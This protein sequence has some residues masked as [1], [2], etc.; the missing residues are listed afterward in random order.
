MKKAG[1]LLLTLIG[2][3][4]L[5]TG[6]GSTPE[7]APFRQVENIDPDHWIY[8]YNTVIE[9][10]DG[11]TGK[12]FSRADSANSF[13]IGYSYLIPDSM[14]GKAFSVTVDAWVRSGDL[15]HVCDIALTCTSND[16]ITLWTGCGAKEFL[17]NPNEWTQVI[18]TI[19]VP[20]D[21]TS[22]NN[23]YINV[24]SHNIDQ[25]SFFD[26]DDMKIEYRELN[27]IN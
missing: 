11:H 3:L 27:A 23:T 21:I 26:V 12:K 19:T 4:T 14:K 22:K 8:N 10:A 7:S 15:S 1:L 6:C 9:G 17:K 2:G 13:G 25:R 18:R 24:I 16:S 20:A 5:I